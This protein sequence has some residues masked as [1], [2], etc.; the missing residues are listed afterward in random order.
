MA[1]LMS[2]VALSVDSILPALGMMSADLQIDSAADAGLIVSFLMIGLGVGQL[3]YGPISD[4][5][6]RKPVVCV[7]LAIFGAGSVMSIWADTLAVMLAGR[8]LQG[9]GLAAPRTVSMAIIRDC[10]NG[11]EMARV[12]SFIMTIFIVVPMLAPVLG[13]AILLTAQWRAIFVVLLLYS[14]AVLAWFV[15]RQRETH[16]PAAR[17]P[18]SMRAIGEAVL[19]VV[20]NR[21]SIGC[22]FVSGAVFGL[23]LSY[24]SAAQPI[25]QGQY[26][27]GALFALYFAA[28]ASSLGFAS[29]V[30][31]R[32]VVR[33][34]MRTI[35]RIAL[36]AL[37]T[38]AL[39]YLGVVALYGGHPPLWSLTA[40]L[41]AAFFCTGLL[42]GNL[43]ALAME[44]LGHI[45]GLGAGVVGAISTLVSVPIAG[46]VTGAYERSLTPFMLGFAACSILAH[47]IFRVVVRR[48]LKEA[49][50][51]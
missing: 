28:V 9:L 14:G 27:V 49:D 50:S 40:F 51:G 15:V 16:P 13:Q 24:I 12:M 21:Q 20:R 10:F 7:G 37:T 4:T 2:L 35:I 23:L 5:I 22:T 30:N 38:L 39:L 18:F 19:E 11:A 26:D 42:A 43:N 47:V 6:G 45:A 41:M 44:P 32:I 36:N 17:R 8:V 31:G 25:F 46:I 34:G 48:D 29:F 1:A 33:H 3:V